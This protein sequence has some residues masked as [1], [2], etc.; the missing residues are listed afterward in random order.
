MYCPE[1]NDS[2]ENACGARAFTGRLTQFGAKSNR[3]VLKMYVHSIKHDDDSGIRAV[4]ELSG[5]NRRDS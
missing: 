3:R 5:K 1:I 4:K 2:M